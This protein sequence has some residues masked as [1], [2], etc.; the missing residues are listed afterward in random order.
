MVLAT[1]K[2]DYW[3]NAK[4]FY[5]IQALEFPE[6]VDIDVALWDVKSEIRFL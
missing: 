1:T 4:V 6:N 2:D 3:A 5:P